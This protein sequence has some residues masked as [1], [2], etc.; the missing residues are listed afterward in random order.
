MTKTDLISQ[1]T[2]KVALKKKDVEKAV[3]AV[4]ETIQDTLAK[5]EKAQFVGF[6]SFEVKLRKP[7]KGRN[8]QTGKVIEIPAANVPVFK[9]GKALKSVVE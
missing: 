8:P 7:R 9:P 3:N 1:V 2:E 6:G 5:G 4:F